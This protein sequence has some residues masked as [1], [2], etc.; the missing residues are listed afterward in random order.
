[1]SGNNPATHRG[2]SAGASHET[3]STS[4]PASLSSLRLLRSSVRELTRALE[5]GDSL[6]GVDPNSTR[7]C[8]TAIGGRLDVVVGDIE[9]RLGVPSVSHELEQAT[10]SFLE[11]NTR[12]LNVLKCLEALGQLS[13]SRSQ[14]NGFPAKDIAAQAC[15]WG[16]LFDGSTVGIGFDPRK[17]PGIDAFV[18]RFRPDGGGTPYHYRLTDIGREAFTIGRFRQ[19]IEEHL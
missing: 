18:E 15:R 7:M 10:A 17:Y 8:L 19:L 2:D 13:F 6:Q 4:V 11:K 1:M 3:T 9:R 14:E 12:A 5:D 16:A